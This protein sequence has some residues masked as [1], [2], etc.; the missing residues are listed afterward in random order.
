MYSM[1]TVAQPLH[2]D[3]LIV[4]ILTIEDDPAVARIIERRLR[5]DGFEVDVAPNATR[6]VQHLLTGL[7]AAVILDVT[8]P[9]RDGFSVCQRMRAIGIKAPILMISTRRRIVDRV[10]GLDCGADDY[11]TKP[12]AASEL[13]ARV[14]ALLRRAGSLDGQPLV[15]SDLRLDPITRRVSRGKR[16]IDLTPREFA[17]LEFMMRRPG[18]PLTRDVIAEHVWGVHWDRRT[19]VIDVVISNLRKKIEGR[20]E[21]RL[22]NPVRGVGYVMAA[23]GLI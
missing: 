6:A 2:E 1:G 4:R 17:L 22:L 12:F 3:L 8:L 10:R 20:S 14:R 11:L 15:I 21:R 23:S 19:N 18:R 9:D 13:S 7:Y 16:V 5:R